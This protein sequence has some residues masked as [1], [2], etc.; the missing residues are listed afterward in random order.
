MNPPKYPMGIVKIDG[1][2]SLHPRVREQTQVRQTS[3]AALKQV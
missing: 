3:D 1:C 2:S